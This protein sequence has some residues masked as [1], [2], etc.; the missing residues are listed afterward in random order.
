MAGNAALPFTGM[1]PPDYQGDILAEQQK[2]AL[3]QALLKQTMGYQGTPDSKRR[4]VAKT[5]LS[6]ALLNSA[7][8]ALAGKTSNEASAKINAQQSAFQQA[9]NDEVNR[10]LSL[11]EEQQT[12][13]AMGSKLPQAQSL[14][15]ALQERD[16]EK[17]Q[18]V[19]KRL[20]NIGQALGPVDAQAANRIL[21]TGQMEPG[22]VP[23]T[24]AAPKFG[25]TP[26]PNGPIP[27]VIN[28]GPNGKQT[29]GFGPVGTTV[30]VDTVGESATTKAYAAKGPEVA[31]KSRDTALAAQKAIEAANRIYTLAEDPMVITG[32]GAN[33]LAGIASLGTKMGFSGPEAAAKT[34]EMLTN[35]A[36][37]TL[38]AVKD[39]PGA[40]TEKERPFLAQAAAGELS[41]TPEA[42]KRV[43]QITASVA[44]NQFMAARRQHAGAA[45]QPGSQ[46]TVMYPF[47]EMHHNLPG[48]EA[49]FP[50]RGTGA[51]VSLAGTTPMAGKPQAAPKG[52]A[53][54]PMTMEEY[55][56]ALKAR[57]GR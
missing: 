21:S 28:S 56:A 15:K 48:T 2:Q 52:T 45:A 39:L 32:F 22:L 13:A 24:P 6:H 41:Y 11:P 33:Q 8:G 16:K 18:N 29:G 4:I 19:E 38:A 26:G 55:Q 7:I 53:E 12:A 20:G 5:P 31:E 40:I 1:M 17:A 50:Q 47:P 14:A 35:M 43:A 25:S 57:G 36:K 27:T 42:I 46:A 51:D 9:G 10:I 23:Q 44:H 30:N 37:G 3:A 49:D 54:N 34:Q